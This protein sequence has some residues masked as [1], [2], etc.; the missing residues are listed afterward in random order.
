MSFEKGVIQRNV[1][2]S[3]NQ[4]LVPVRLTRKPNQHSL[5]FVKGTIFRQVARLD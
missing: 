4:K 3:S 5:H 2:I 1:M